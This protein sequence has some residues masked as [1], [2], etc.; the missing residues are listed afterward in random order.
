[1]RRR[2]GAT[3]AL[4]AAAVVGTVSTHTLGAPQASAGLTLGGAVKDAVGPPSARGAFHL[5]GRADVLFFRDRGADMALGPYVDV[6]TS[7]FD[8]IDLGGGATWLLPLR[9]DLPL[10]ISAGALV[11]QGAGRS[12]AP[13]MVS[14]LFFGSRSYNFHSLYGM[15]A[16][17]FAQTRWIPASPATLDVIAGVQIDAEMLA[18][19]VLLLVGALRAN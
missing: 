19:P 13:G 8:A 17:F 5:G 2:R 9:D 15:A 4:G 6:A 7:S 18:L 11:R 14:G 3:W 16:G 1:M 10:A 12:W